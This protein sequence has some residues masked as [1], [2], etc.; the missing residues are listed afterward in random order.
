MLL[1]V[2]T[3]YQRALAIHVVT[4]HRITLE[5]LSSLR[6]KRQFGLSYGGLV[7]GLVDP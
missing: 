6:L 1:T 2:Y 4:C 3:I 7:R 5:V